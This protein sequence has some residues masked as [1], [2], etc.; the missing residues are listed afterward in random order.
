MTASTLTVVLA[1]S[2]STA[3]KV[4]D[5][6]EGWTRAGLIDPLLWTVMGENGLT[7]TTW[8]G[9]DR[10][11]VD[12]R[13]AI[14]AEPYGLIRLIACHVLDSAEAPRDDTAVEFARRAS[15]VQGAVGRA[16]APQQ[17]LVRLS[18]LI[19]ASGAAE[20][21][22]ETLSLPA[23]ANVLVAPEQRITPRHASVE[24]G[25]ADL[26]THAAAA[27]ASVS[28]RW[29][30]SEVGPFDGQDEP[31]SSASPRLTVVRSF[32]RALRIR[33]AVGEVANELWARRRSEAWAAHAAGATPARDPQ[34]VVG[35]LLR[36]FFSVHGERLIYQPGPAP[37]RPQLAPVSVGSAAQELFRYA[38]RGFRDVPADVASRVEESARQ[39][40]SDF[41]QRA[42]AAGPAAPIVSGARA[43]HRWPVDE[44]ANAAEVNAADATEATVELARDLLHRAGGDAPAPPPAGG[45]WQALRQMSF[46]A[47]DGSPMPEGITEPREGATRVVL[48]SAADVAPDPQAGAFQF[49]DVPSSLQHEPFL[50][51]PIGVCDAFQATQA[52]ASLDNRLVIGLSPKPVEQQEEVTDETSP[53]AAE[54]QFSDDVARLRD[55][56]EA[57]VADQERSLL[58][59]LTSRVSDALTDGREDL[60]ESHKRVKQG[61]PRVDEAALAAAQTDLRRNWFVI[62][63][64]VLILGLLTFWVLGGDG[65]GLTPAVAVGTATGWIVIWAVSLVLAF[66]RYQGHVSHLRYEYQRRHAEFLDAFERS[67][68]A[69]RQVDSLASIYRQLR[70]WA[71]VIGWM[72]HHPE[73]PVVNTPASA[74]SPSEVDV[75]PSVVVTEGLA[76]ESSLRRV[77]AIV[78]RDLFRRG[79]ILALYARY[80]REAIERMKYEQGLSDDDSDPDVD[81]DLAF[82]TP[83]GYLLEEL[84]TG[85]SAQSWTQEVLGELARAMQKLPPAEMVVAVGGDREAS[86]NAETF[87]AEIVPPHLS[88][89]PDH[90][91]L[92]M[93]TPQARQREAERIS[94]SAVW[95][96]RG[97]AVEGHHALKPLQADPD[98]AF[99]DV[100][101]LE[102]VRLDMTDPASYDNVVFFKRAALADEPGFTHPT[103]AVG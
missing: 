67:L 59:K 57:W 91:F 66:M 103:D 70:C 10:A 18:L 82:P 87:L 80:R 46:G 88:S 53:S 28:G 22:P 64:A 40:L 15:Q 93:W 30:A 33:G 61:E 73:G 84:R 95:A 90:L 60:L 9:G 14:A 102:C 97:L 43:D 79:W 16:L 68:D 17:R 47:I 54:E 4:R 20:I 101:V 1:R 29:R 65:A 100:F 76:S 51:A 49:S 32:V 69:A 8:L 13:A 86:I 2:T 11:E 31:D 23:A 63:L 94:N 25:D 38:A 99:R 72:V 35:T 41:A 62:T 24:V 34:G 56:L 37:R 52:R 45:T 74:D 75:P 89:E 85:R 92:P 81:R 7:V 44:P 6:L 21:S 96:P 19:P 48:A 78:G 3:P 77:G 55:Q 58:W 27:I 39:P 98:A 71:E 50:Q 36:D 5:A 42:A 83:L 26:V 12:L